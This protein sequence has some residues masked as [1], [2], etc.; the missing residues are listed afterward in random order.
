MTDPLLL[1][2][3]LFDLCAAVVYAL[4]LWSDALMEGT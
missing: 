2:S 1:L 4:A 3:A